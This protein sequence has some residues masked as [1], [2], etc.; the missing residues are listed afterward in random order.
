MKKMDSLI[1]VD[2][3]GIAVAGA[4]LA[5]GLWGGVLNA[6]ETGNRI[7]SLTS[8]TTQL[9]DTLG[10]VRAT[11]DRKGEELAARQAAFG[12][13]DLL[14]DS[15]PI[16]RELR[17][18]ADLARQHDLALTD[19]SPLAANHYAGVRELRYHLSAVGSF[20]SHVGFLRDFEAGDSWADVTFLKLGAPNAEAADGRVGE[21]T[22]S[23]YSTEKEDAGETVAP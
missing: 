20:A 12:A 3:G 4:C 5:V 18:V 9:E 2:L 11:L 14:P 8:E 10:Q 23:L 13:G 16:E 15:T 7:R 22:V 21:F 17:A 6:T 19:F 1:L